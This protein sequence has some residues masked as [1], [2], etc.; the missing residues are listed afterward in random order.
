MIICDGHCHVGEGSLKSQSAEALLANMDRSGVQKAVIV[1]VEECLAADNEEGNRYILDLCERYPERFWGFASA[2]PWFGKKARKILRDYLSRGL[3]G[4]K[5]NP[6]VQGFKISDALIYPFMEL[7]QEFGVPVYFHTGTP[8]CAMPFQLFDLSGRYSGVRF[9][10]GHSGYADFWQD[11][12]FIASHSENIWFDTS[13]SLTP[14]TEALVSACGAGR[15]LFGSDSPRSS[16]EY[17][18]EKVMLCRAEPKD[19]EAM[20]GANLVALLG[21]AV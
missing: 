5:F 13:L 7:A 21:G 8:V 9:I 6:V 10:L 14:R 4:I 19:K 12:P 3:C 18:I 20:M 11:I 1:P 2:N 15:I 16:L 17:E